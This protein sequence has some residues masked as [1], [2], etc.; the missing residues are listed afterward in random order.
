MAPK[1]IFI[2]NAHPAAT[3]LN[4]SLAETYADAARAAGHDVRL[5]HL[6]DLSFD[7]DYGFSG[8]VNQKPLEPAIEEVLKNIEWSEHMVLTTPMWWGGLPGK[9]KGVF[10]RILLPGRAF[11]TR[12]TNWLGFPSPMLAGRSGRV[13]MTSDTPGWFMR[14]IY[15]NAMIRQ[16]RDQIL[17]FVGIKP[18]RIT[19]FAGAT[20]P[21]AG[22]VDRW[23]AQVRDSGAT[24]A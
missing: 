9:L 18:A 8:Y 24:A 2:L 10:D 7:A 19:Y 3:S 20:H 12:E 22:V 14:W 21:K 5:T 6:N 1:R 4:R 23:V 11:S 17:G 16:L 13:I 15:H